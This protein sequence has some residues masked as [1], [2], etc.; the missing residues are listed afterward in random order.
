IREVGVDAFRVDTAFYV[1]PSYFRDFLY[2]D[3]AAA[4]GVLQVARATGRR[5]FHVFGE[6][7]ALDKP[8]QDAQ[9]R[10]IDGYMRDAE[11]ALLPGMIHFPLY[12]S[13]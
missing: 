1:P 3:D 6:G 4:P 7:F 5:D 12:G 13:L 9:M 11:G 10:R 2:A 8:F